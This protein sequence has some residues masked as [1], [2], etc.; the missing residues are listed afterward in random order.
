MYYKHTQK[1]RQLDIP[2]HVFSLSAAREPAHNK[3][4][5]P[6]S[7]KHLEAHAL[8]SISWLGT[9]L[10][11]LREISRN[12]RFSHSFRRYHVWNHDLWNVHV[13]LRVSR[14][15]LVNVF[16][17]LWKSSF[18]RNKWRR[19]HEQRMQQVLHVNLPGTL[20]RLALSVFVPSFCLN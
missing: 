14:L 4:G 19:R 20:S 8:Y 12:F 2:L 18:L 7:I 6:F 17:V 1:F 5:G 11:W 3:G 10:Q 9:V 15:R 13:L 16:P